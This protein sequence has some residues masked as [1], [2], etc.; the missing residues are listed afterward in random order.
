A[1]YRPYSEVAEAVLQALLSSEAGLDW[2]VLTPPMGFGSYAPGETTGT[3]QLGGELPLNDAEGKSAISGA[4]Y[5]L[6]FV[7]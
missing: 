1:Q 7:D 2:F 6:A 4:D 3:Y 5:A